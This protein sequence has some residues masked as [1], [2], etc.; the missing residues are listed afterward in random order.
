MRGPLGL[1]CLLVVASTA[2]AGEPFMFRGGTWVCDAPGRY[3]EVVGRQEAGESL[4]D[5]LRETRGH[6]VF[7]EE[8]EQDDMLP[9]FV[10]LLGEEDSHARVTFTMADERRFNVLHGAVTYVRYVG[11]TGRDRLQTRDEWRRLPGR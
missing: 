2:S 8:E 6:C 4:G 5:L 1:I 9:P 3:D 10:Q 7:V 11:W